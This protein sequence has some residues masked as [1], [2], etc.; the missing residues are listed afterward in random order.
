MKA[1]SYLVR[2]AM[3]A[4]R[5]LGDETMVMSAADSTLF[6]LNEV[7]SVIWESA[8][9]A[10]SFEEIVADRICAHFDVAVDIARADAEAVVE[11]LVANGLLI[12]SDRPVAS[13]N[14]HG[15][16]TPCPA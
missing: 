13:A 11:T 3:V 1:T 12:V 10:T 5:A 14:P 9:G 6:T 7:A 16:V 4:A 15:P 8:D 2:S